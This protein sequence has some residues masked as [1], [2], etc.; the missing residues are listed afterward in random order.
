MTY[1]NAMKRGFRSI[2]KHKGMMIIVFIGP[3]F[4][5][6]LFGGIYYND[7]VK[8]VPVAVL[9][10]DCT[11][12]SRLVNSYFITNERFQVTN[13]PESK[14][15]L[16]KLID[17]GEVQMG[18]YIPK[19]FESKVGTYKSSEILVI[20][21]GSN[22]VTANNAL[23]QATMIVQSVSAGIE[24]KLIQGKGVLPAV[25]ENM[26]LVYN[27]GE[28]ILFDPKMTYMNYLMICFLAIFIQQLMLAAM[29]G[30]FF[31]ESEYIT[32]GDTAKKVL[33]IVS[34]CFIAMIPSLIVSVLI[35]KTLFHVPFTGNM[36]TAVI[37]TLCFILALT[38]PSL[39]MASLTKDRIKYS[40]F[41]FM[42]S[43]PTFATAGCVW[44]VEQMPWLLAV[45]MKIS[46]PLI[47]YAK[48]VQEVIIKGMGIITVLPNIISLLLFSAIWFPIGI[49][50][51]KKSFTLT[52][53][54]TIQQ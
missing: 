41:E 38:G 3:I 17:N 11:S 8:D 32:H 43:L 27:I 48:T 52:Y 4:L 45:I 2:F 47:Y 36:L 15:E 49:H 23:A 25:A 7:Y 34:S 40:Q 39:V 10:E 28:R 30:S 53:S 51:Y 54:D 18:L 14:Q 16:Q 29:G 13:Y 22:V 31:R 12:L 33:G 9:D 19:G 46:W 50:L 5:T 35:L 42:L 1:M 37:M 26:A 20:T 6:L 44:P 21:D 24:M